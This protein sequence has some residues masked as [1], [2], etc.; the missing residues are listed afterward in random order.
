MGD[1][2]KELFYYKDQLFGKTVLCNCDDPYESNFFLY[3][4]LNFAALGLKRLIATSYGTSKVAKGQLSFF[5][6]NVDKIADIPVDYYGVMGV[7]ITFIEKY[8]PN[9]FEILGI[10]IANLGLEAGVKPY[11]EEHKKYRKEVQKR[12]AVDGDLYMVI[13]GIVVVPYARIL[14]R[15]KV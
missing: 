9:Q 7:P 5:A 10:G 4:A 11:K 8:N 1:V 12:G 13:K 6:I 15:R 14:I 2:E 3:F